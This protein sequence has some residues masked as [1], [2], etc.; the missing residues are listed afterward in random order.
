MRL[1]GW[2]PVVVLPTLRDAHG[3]YPEVLEG[4]APQGEVVVVGLY[5]LVFF[6]NLR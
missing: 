6:M 4:R 5:Q 3:V 2:A 1:E